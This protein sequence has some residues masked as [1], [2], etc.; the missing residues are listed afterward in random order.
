MKALH[1]SRILLAAVPLAGIALAAAGCGSGAA[2]APVPLDA[3]PATAAFVAPVHV[4]ISGLPATGL[5]TVQAQMVGQKGQ[6][7]Q[8]AAVFRASTAGTL[9]LSTAVP[10]SGSYHTADAAGLLWSLHPASPNNTTNPLSISAPAFTVRLTVLTGGHVRATATLQ[11]QLTVTAS[12]QTVRQDGFAGTLYTSA[13]VKPGAPA[14]VALDGDGENRATAEGLAMSGYP[15][16]AL[17]YYNQPGLPPCEC[18]IPLEY[19]ARA[20]SWLRTQPATRGRPVVL[21][22]VSDSAEAVLLVAS[23]LPHLADAVVANSPT[24]TIDIE[25]SGTG[26]AFTFGGKPLADGMTIPV[27]SIRIPLLMGDGGQDGLQDSAGSA[28]FIM[29]ELHGSADHAPA[30][31][32]YYP[33]AGHAYFGLPPYYPFFTELLLA[34]VFHEAWLLSG[35]PKRKNAPELG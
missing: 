6:P 1:R 19:F 33:G 17:G 12:T 23:Y 25:S 20:V 11:R 4:S 9:N 3:G 2:N 34:L 27:T 21:Y 5:V 8:S 10:V 24:A 30:T 15:A 28:T 31:N 35:A 22:G 32:L 26:P 14:V 29:G 7:W 18:S 13:A 16:L